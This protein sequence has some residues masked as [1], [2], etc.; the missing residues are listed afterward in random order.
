[1]KNKIQTLGMCMAFLLFSINQIV[2]AQNKLAEKENASEVDQIEQAKKSG[3]T[4]KEEWP[5][6]A[7]HS[8]P[9]WFRD[10]KF[11]IFTCIGPATLATQNKTTEWYGWAMYDT[12]GVYWNNAPR[13]EAKPSGEFLRHKELFGGDQNE[14]GYKDIIKQFNPTK[15]NAEEWADLFDK[16]GAKFMGPIG[17]FHDNYLNWDSDVS[18]WNSKDM[19]G[20]DIT[21]ELEKAIRKRNMKYLITYHHAFT[22][23]WYYH[24]FAFDGGITGNE[25]LYGK[26]HGFSPDSDSFEP[27]PD[28]DFEERWFDILKESADKYSPDLF[29]FDMGLELLSD[30]IRKKAFAYLLNEAEQKKQDIGLCY[31]IKFD[32]CIPP[33]A[34]ILDYEKGRSTGLRADPW[35]SDTPLGGWFYN[36]RKSRSPEAIVEIL[37][38]VVSKNGCLLLDVSPK[39]DGTIPEDQKETL[40]GIGEWLNM[41]GEAIYNTRPWKIDGEGPTTLKT[42]DHFNENW[43]AI[44]TENDIRYTRSKDENT[45]YVIVLD[46]PTKGKITA[47][48]LSTILPYF[49]KEIANI[50][51]I[52]SDEKVVW[53][54]DVYGLELSFPNNHPGKHAFCYKVKLVTK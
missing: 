54:R 35:L 7:K 15:F 16:A 25:D 4:F 44:Y 33:R 17:V 27:Y 30:N 42:D 38:D 19:A 23:Y 28:A 14:V 8:V 34:G 36:G 1:M 49:D 26:V 11:G 53:N 20:V 18:R 47:K 21:G 3:K 12:I 13:G 37:C 50:S 43:E 9:E 39:A 2:Y 6:I 5:S 40:L 51:L 31:K 10:A 48:M 46:R 45:L 22:W 24:S 52:G 29:W 32:V 41:N